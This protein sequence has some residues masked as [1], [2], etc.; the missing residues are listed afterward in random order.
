MKKLSRADLL[1]L[2]QYSQERSAYRERVIAHKKNRQVALGPHATLYFEDRLTIQYQIQEMLRVERIF[3]AEGIEEELG[4][5]NPLIPD[6]RNW[7][8][9]FMLEYGDVDVRREALAKLVGVEHKVWAQVGDLDRT[10]AIANEDLERS[11]DDKTSAVHFMRFEL[12]GAAVAALEDGAPLNFGI[13]YPGFE[14]DVRTS[15]ATR[16]SLMADLD[17]APTSPGPYR[18]DGVPIHLSERSAQPVQG[19]TFDGP[20][21]ERY[22]EDRTSEDEPGRLMMIE[23]TPTNWAAWECHTLADEVVHVLEG[24]GEF[25]QQTEAGDVRIPVQPGDTVINPRGVWHTADITEP[26]KAIYL[27]PCRGTEHRLRE[28]A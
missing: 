27:T 8:A 25:I 4:A 6:G 13:D 24:R 19:F 10:Y 7:K 11:T 17:P 16:L 28:E 18:L 14:Q 1:G 9:T 22:V 12:S 26:M 3:E 15:D 20:S 23:S 2:E 21:F 5:Y